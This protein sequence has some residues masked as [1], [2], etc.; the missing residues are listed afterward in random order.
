MT[1]DDKNII[2]SKNTENTGNAENLHEGLEESVDKMHKQNVGDNV[3]GEE[4]RDSV[5]RDS[6]DPLSH[7]DK[8]PNQ[9]P[10]RVHAQR[11]QGNKG[12]ALLKL[13]FTAI[14]AVLLIGVALVQNSEMPWNVEQQLAKLNT[15][16]SVSAAKAAAEQAR[17]EN[18]EAQAVAKDVTD[19]TPSDDGENQQ[20][21]EQT[22]KNTETQSNRQAAAQPTSGGN[23]TWQLPANSKIIKN[24]GYSYDE[25]WKDYRFHSGVDIALPKGKGV[26]ALAAGKVTESGKTKALGEYI[27]IDY[28]NNLVGYYFG[29]DVKDGLSAGAAV[30]KGQTIG[31]VTDSP[32]QESSLQPHYH[33]AL[34]QNGQTVDPAKLMK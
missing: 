15:G 9:T 29:I 24:Y 10:S 23:L 6:A 19:Q 13:T 12:A 18:S 25:T 4:Y 22:G 8:I 5:I 31:T 26:T 3:L 34:L 32:L 20:T 27:R 28:G 7:G 17:Q 16:D 2:D 1:K 11:R 21:A 33:F 30:T 14:L